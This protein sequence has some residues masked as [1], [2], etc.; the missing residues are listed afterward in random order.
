[1]WPSDCAAS[2]TN[3]NAKAA[4]HLGDGRGR[5]DHAA[6]T[7]QRVNSDLWEQYEK[8]RLVISRQVHH[9][10]DVVRCAVFG[11]FFG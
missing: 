11:Q 10:L 7:G 8:N 4:A 3:G 9:S 1:M 5:L 2:I 6:V